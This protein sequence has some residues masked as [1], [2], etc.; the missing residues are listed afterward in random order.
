MAKILRNIYPGLRAKMSYAGEST[1]ELAKIL[2]TSS[3]S[4]RKRL[5][6]QYFFDLDQIKKLTDHY[7][8]SFDDLFAVV[9]QIDA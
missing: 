5:R 7:N 6:G 3:D 2:N 9:D 1:E 8:C 4:V